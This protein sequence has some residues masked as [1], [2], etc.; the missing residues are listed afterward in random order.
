MILKSQTHLKIPLFI[1]LCLVVLSSKANQPKQLNHLFAKSQVKVAEINYQYFNT[2]QANEPFKY[3]INLGEYGTY[4]LQ[5]KSNSI[6]AS[7]FKKDL[8][9]MN[10]LP[11]SFSGKIANQP[12]SHVS[13]TV[14]QNF[15]SG[16]VHTGETAIYFEPLHHFNK[17]AKANELIIYNEKDALNEK[18]R[19]SHQ[20]QPI[21][22]KVAEQQQL[23]TKRLACDAYI[24]ELVLVADYGM[25]Q[26]YG[27]ATDVRN[28]LST[29]LNA[30]KQNYNSVFN[31]PINFQLVD[32]YISTSAANDLWDAQET[33][34]DLLLAEFAQSNFTDKV[35]DLASLWVSREIWR[36]EDGER[37]A[38]AGLAFDNGICKEGQKY[39]LISEYNS[40][41]DYM[42]T[43]LTHEI[44]HNFSAVHDP[45]GT[46]F[47]MSNGVRSETWSPASIDKIN[48]FYPNT[49]CLCS[50]EFVDLLANR[51]VQFGFG[52]NTYRTVNVQNTGN[53]ISSTTKVGLFLS[54]DSNINT[55]D[56]LVRTANVNPLAPNEEITVQLLFSFDEVDLPGGTYYWGLIA[57]AENNI[58]EG[59]ETNNLGCS[60]TITLEGIEPTKPDLIIE[61]C[62]AVSISGNTINTGSITLKNIGDADAAGN[63]LRYYLSN[64]SEEYYITASN[65]PALAAGA[66]FSRPISRDISQVQPPLPAG[67]YNLLIKADVNNAVEESNEGNNTCLNTSTPFTV[68]YGCKD[69]TAQNYNP[70]ATY[71]DNSICTYQEDEADL[72]IESCGLVTVTGNMINTGSIKV[73]NIGGMAASASHVGVYLNRL[74]GSWLIAEVDFPVLQAG[75]ALSKSILIDISNI[76]P[77]LSAG[78]YTLSFWTDKNRNVAEESE[79]NNTCANSNNPSFTVTYGCKDVNAHNYNANATF[80]DASLCQTCSDGII[81]GDEQGADCGGSCPNICP[82]GCQQEDLQVLYDFHDATNGESWTTKWNFSED[83]SN[84]YGITLNANG[85]VESINMFNNN[86]SGYLPPTLGKLSALKRLY[87]GFNNVSGEIP[88]SISNL[89]QLETLNLSSNN[90]TGTIP[91]SLGN[92]TNLQYLILSNNQLSGSMPKELGNLSKLKHLTLYANALSEGIPEEIGKLFNLEFLSFHSN[93]LTGSIPYEF[94]NLVKLKKL[95]LMSNQLTGSIPSS[96]GNLSNLKELKLYNNQLENYIPWQLGNLNSLE[97]MSLSHNQLSGPIPLQF[98]KLTNLEELELANNQLTGTLPAEL[99]DLS[100]LKILSAD[101]NELS[102]CFHEN[103]RNLCDA[104]VGVNYNNNFTVEWDD[105]CNP[106][107]NNACQP[108]GCQYNDANSML[109]LSFD[110][111]LEGRAGERPLNYNG[112]TYDERGYL[113]TALDIRGDLNNKAELTYPAANNINL[114][115][116]TI[117]AWV[118]HFWDGDA[119]VQHTLLQYGSMG[120]LLFFKDG[121]NYFRLLLNR[122]SPAGFPEINVGTST[123]FWEPGEWKHVAATWG[124][125]EIIL[126]IDGEVADRNTYTQ[127]IASIVDSHFTIGSDAGNANWGGLVDQLRISNKVRTK[128]EI[129]SFRYACIGDRIKPMAFNSL[130]NHPNPFNANTTIAFDLLSDSKVSLYVTDMMGKKIATLLS[131]EQKSEGANTVTFNASNYPSGMYYY[132]LQAGDYLETQKMILLE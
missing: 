47:I 23:V 69:A 108:A 27:S 121:G 51:C 7:D 22:F 130:S 53:T 13:L 105:F 46:E 81:N 24:V 82:T 80:E 109:N 132:T 40:S 126:Y 91:A 16:Y 72:I 94:G 41:L 62:N 116:G 67:N 63:L 29:V 39:N 25:V 45:A 76:N 4:E 106:S 49:N 125:G 2:Q 30:T 79:V 88:S 38:K 50:S 10:S 114:N 61:N 44:G 71:A 128:S 85:C 17:Q 119:P 104:R 48:N 102:G 83:V 124:N 57:D 35:Y 58:E 55:D 112:L 74:T 95:W 15:M 98:G 117:E 1:T 42:E 84:W 96:L 120:G 3:S 113:N 103:L 11:L 18:L 110:F 127:P 64:Q 5:L 32:E 56:Y 19:C 8:Q 100:M 101:R 86:L 77:P 59:S 37:R 65:F 70:T 60:G 9:K 129:N 131:N 20:H 78:T 122:F 99:G 115:Q 14:N 31:N 66:S 75:A 118:M 43:V 12:E 21:S 107:N 68:T 90:L 54:E 33:N 6:F 36:L 92:L 73:K 52:G 87:L 34:A 93:S 89:S 123:Q 26:K 111:T 28:R 97:E